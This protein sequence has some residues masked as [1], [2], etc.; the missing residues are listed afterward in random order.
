MLRAWLSSAY[1]GSSQ[2]SSW[3]EAWPWPTLLTMLLHPIHRQLLWIIRYMYGFDAPGPPQPSVEELVPNN[4]TLIRRLF[5]YK[6]MTE[7]IATRGQIG[8][9]G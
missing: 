3:L 2:P 5:Q 8:A 7:E 4:T 1:L 9:R 6:R